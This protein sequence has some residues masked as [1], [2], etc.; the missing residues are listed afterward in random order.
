MNLLAIDTSHSS[1]SVAVCKNDEIYGAQTDTAMN[2]SQLA[3]LFIDEQM[4]KAALDPCDLRG[5]LCMGG[6]GSFTGLRIG[7]SIA[8][9]LSLSLSIPFVPVPTLDCIA[10]SA[11]NDSAINN[12]LLFPVIQASKNAW[13]YSIFKNSERLAPDQE[14]SVDGF[15]KII[16]GY[17]EK[18]TIAGP[19]ARQLYDTLPGEYSK[20][21]DIT[22]TNTNFAKELISIAKNKNLFQNDTSAYLYSG[23]EYI[24]K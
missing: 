7:Y 5:V 15:S 4:K 23:P 24:K 10:H 14:F 22:G 9:A 17:H 1:L 11:M 20:S 19:G 21:I 13:F 12:G 6:P 8:K 18:I 2:H 16:S 3:V